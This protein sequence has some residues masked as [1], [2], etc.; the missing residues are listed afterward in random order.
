MAFQS[1]KERPSSRLRATLATTGRAAERAMFDATNG[2][3]THKGAIW[4]LG[5]LAAAAGRDELPLVRGR[6]VAAAIARTAGEIASFEDCYESAPNALTE[7]NQMPNAKRRLVRH[8]LGAVGTPNAKRQT[9]NADLSH[10]Q[11]VANRFGVTGARG[12]AI[13][14][15]PH[16]H[17]VGLPMLRARRRAHSPESI[18]RLDALL[19]IM[20][21]LTDTCLLYRGGKLALRTAQHG[22]TAVLAAGGAGTPHG[23]ER[24]LA[25]DHHLLQLGVSPGGS[26]DL[27]AGTLFL[28]A[29]EQGQTRITA[30]RTIN[31]TSV[32]SVSLW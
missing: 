5:L 22:S 17:E 11:I 6:D 29:V 1:M 21:R 19:A 2:S 18:A 24:L 25:L 16:L 30:D 13:A 23:H 32:N 27:L 26:A 3:N 15:F 31:L 20:S 8:S 4:T 10:G 28:D 9:P 14:G 12:E 7:P